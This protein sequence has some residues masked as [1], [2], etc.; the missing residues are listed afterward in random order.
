[1]V[2]TF[3]Y[4]RL[5]TPIMSS[6]KQYCLP[7]CKQLLPLILSICK[8]LGDY[9]HSIS[10]Q[11]SHT[12]LQR[13]LL[14]AAIPLKCVIIRLQRETVPS[15]SDNNDDERQSSFVD[16]ARITLFNFHNVLLNLYKSP[17]NRMAGNPFLAALL[18]RATKA[19][20]LVDSKENELIL[21]SLCCA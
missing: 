3:P 12:S 20:A 15:N 13:R 6:I 16:F 5:P 7:A 11:C 10:L 2:S 21:H 4:C 14:R 19:I 8:Q 17:N 9:C 18:Q 1:M